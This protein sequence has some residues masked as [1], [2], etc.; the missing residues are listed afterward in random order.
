M[1]VW[2][3]AL[4]LLLRKPLQ[5]SSRQVLMGGMVALL[6][7]Y[8]FVSEKSTLPQQLSVFLPTFLTPVWFR[9]AVASQ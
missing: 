2:D 9:E 7:I 4:T 8:L 6:F 3:P 5:V 1:S